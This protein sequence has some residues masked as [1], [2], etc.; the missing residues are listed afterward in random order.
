MFES[1]VETEKAPQ[2]IARLKDYFLW[3]QTSL[4]E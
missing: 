4:S 3:Y 1:G 2:P